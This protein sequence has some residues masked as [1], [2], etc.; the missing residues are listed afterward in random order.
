MDMYEKNT[1]LNTLIE[2]MECQMNCKH[3]HEIKS[4]ELLLLLR[5]FYKKE[6]LAYLFHRLSIKSF[7]KSLVCLPISGSGFVV[8]PLNFYVS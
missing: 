5:G 2:Y 4:L 1:D 8:L 7:E 6:E 3:L